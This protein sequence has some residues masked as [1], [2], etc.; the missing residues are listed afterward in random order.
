MEAFSIN[1]QKSPMAKSLKRRSR[2]ADALTELVASQVQS[3]ST[4][5]KSLLDQPLP[6]L[7]TKGGSG[8]K[9]I[10]RGISVARSSRL[11]SSVSSNS[12]KPV[13]TFDFGLLSDASLEDRLKTLELKCHN[14]EYAIAGLQGYDI[15]TPVLP[16]KPPKRRSIHDLFIETTAPP[17]SRATSA[18][19]STLLK[20]SSDPASQ[21]DEDRG[22]VQR[23]SA[24]TI[25][26]ARPSPGHPQRSAAPSPSTINQKADHYPDLLKMIEEERAARK[27]LEAQVLEL[28]KQVAAYATSQPSLYATP[29]PESMHTESNE[30]R[31]RPLHRTPAFPRLSRKMIAETSRFS[32]SD[33]EESDTE[34]VG[35]HDVYETPQKNKYGF[36]SAEM[37]PRPTVEIF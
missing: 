19:G 37:S 11:N 13:Q 26:P 23:S 5:R 8:A 35:Y 2:S 33:T 31:A 22:Q 9:G 29:S 14:F 36:N 7:E 10:S 21:S 18:Q 30:H 27:Q 28:Q 4:W 20:S 25:R 12:L 3:P 16:S 15:G 1:G 6:N 34:G 17:T 24:T 32:V